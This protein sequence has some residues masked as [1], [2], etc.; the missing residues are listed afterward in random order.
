MIC[1]N[2]K[3]MASKRR[4]LNGKQGGLNSK[5]RF[6]L[7]W[8]SALVGEEVLVKTWLFEASGRMLEKMK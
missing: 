8:R 4:L 6:R 2:P 3:I 5:D 7:W 1:T